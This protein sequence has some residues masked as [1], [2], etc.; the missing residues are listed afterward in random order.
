[1]PEPV[2]TAIGVCLVTYATAQ[3]AVRRSGAVSSEAQA[4]QNA[5][6]QIVDWAELSQAL[7]G[8]K[9][10]AISGLR[11]L[12]NDCG[13]PSWD[14]GDS[15]A[16]NPIAVLNAENLIRAL[17]DNTPLPDLAP[18]PDGSISLDWAQGLKRIFTLSVG[19]T[20]RLAFAWLDGSDKGHGVARFNGQAIPPRVLEGIESIV[21]NARLR[22][23]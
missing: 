23:A 10:A 14:G 21:G 20:D 15:L 2:S 1:M 3:A 7:F 5:V 22:T 11:A 9:A 16:L 8:P 18:E 12:A 17:P 4:V 19:A 13:Q 6:T